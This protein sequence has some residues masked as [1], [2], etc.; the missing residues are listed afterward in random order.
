MRKSG[1]AGGIRKEYNY[2]IQIPDLSQYKS[3]DL[4]PFQCIQCNN[5]FHRPKNEV[6][7]LVKGNYHGSLT[8]CSKVCN[9]LNSQKR[10]E[11]K[12]EYCN[13]M[14]IKKASDMRSTYHF[15][16]RSCSTKYQNSNKTKGFRR[17]KAEFLIESLIKND[18]PNLNLI[19]SDRNLLSNGLEIDIH[20]PDIKLAIELNGPIHFQPI[21]GKDKFD[22]TVENDA[23]KISQL[24][25]LGYGIIVVDISSLGYWKTAEPKLIYYYKTKIQPIIAF[26]I[27]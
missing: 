20:L 8:L 6:Q 18:F 1:G 2:M 17:S 27:E 5:V 14:F 4:I 21:Y 23:R 13:K 10:H 12:C 25:N 19:S 22:K 24:T 7:R 11:V 16:S 3:R 9:G 15:C 26:E